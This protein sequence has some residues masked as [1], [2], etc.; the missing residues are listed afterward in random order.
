MRWWRLSGRWPRWSISLFFF[1]RFDGGE[2]LPYRLFLIGS[3]HA[4]AGRH[5]ER[6]LFAT[7]FYATLNFNLFGVFHMAIYSLQMS[8]ATEST[9]PNLRHRFG[10]DDIGKASFPISFTE[11]GMTILNRPVQPE[12]ARHPIFVTEL[13]MET[14]FKSLHTK[15]ASSFIVSVPSG[16]IPTPSLISYSAIVFITITCT[17]QGSIDCFGFSLSLMYKYSHFS[18]K[19]RYPP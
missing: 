18:T 15:N 3:H 10:D 12:K 8:A 19:I 14:L 13:G 16:M 2:L 5:V 11:S 6:R 1:H 17:S 9:V 4:L 7:Q